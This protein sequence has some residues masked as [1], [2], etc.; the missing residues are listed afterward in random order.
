[1]TFDENGSTGSALAA[2]RRGYQAVPIRDG[3]K[4]PHVAGWVH[5]RWADED[6]ISKAFGQWAEEGAHGVGLLLGKPSGGLVDVDMDHPKAL[7]LRRFFL[8]PTSMQTGRAGRPQSHCWYRVEKGLPET[9]QYKMPDG[10][11]I[12]ELRSTGA[13]TV[14]PP[15]VHPTG[16]AYRWEGEPWG[17]DGPAKVDG[18]KLSW[19]VALTALGV[20]L[21][22]QWPAKGSRHEAYLAL[23]GGL[24][25]YGKDAVHPFWERNI[26]ILIEGL[27]DATH[28]RDGAD[29]RV[30]EV[31]PS[32]IK[33]LREGDRTYG[34]N[35]LGQM[36]G[37]DHAASA[38]RIA[39]E[40]ASLFGIGPGAVA[41]ST[42]ERW[43]FNRERDVEEVVEG[44]KEGTEQEKSWGWGRVDLE[45]YTSGRIVM[46][47][48]TLLRRTDGRG[49]FYPGRVNVLY[50][51][52][53]S[54]KSWIAM[55][56]GVQEIAD[57]GRL[58]FVDLEDTPEGTLERIRLLGVADDDLP[59]QF[60]YVNPE[61]PLAELQMGKYGPNVTEE[62]QANSKVFTAL[63]KGFD[64]SIIVLDGMTVLYGIHGLDTNDAS[65][66]EV[67]TGWLK[68]LARRGY[69]IILIDHTGKNGGKF[70]T[71][72][73]SGQKKAM[74]QG[75][76]YRV[77]VITRPVP[78][79]IGQVELA[80]AKDR[81]GKMKR[82]L[83][84]G[85]RQQAEPIAGI[86]TI[87]S[88]VDGITKVWIDPPDMTTVSAP[89]DDAAM[90]AAVDKVEK[91]SAADREKRR[92]QA[93]NDR[94]LDIVGEVAAESDESKARLP[95]IYEAFGD[96]LSQRTIR[97]RL[98][99]WVEKKALEVGG[100]TTDRW[101]RPI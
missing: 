36:I 47:E 2:F 101:Y 33:R 26:H 35:R 80:T 82:D 53:E 55:F 89:G 59:S 75:A 49:L 84:L 88:S 100:S 56:C 72:I 68:R 52:S 51:L 70:A 78:G 40:I 48:P 94:L 58:L 17:G 25:W 74:V 92:V 20:V 24:L 69:T 1:M 85:I 66:T 77:D 13:Q 67:I 71:P 54:A 12:I 42:T 10:T 11:M 45:P 44:A 38:Q 31:V 41:T 65:S 50:G 97:N 14:I 86:V 83:P 96:T 93:E 90:A 64:P 87:D 99:A 57:G 79:A 34:W 19:Q 29:T 60:A 5:Q 30:K 27:A 18:Q 7:T 23:A 39:K 63:L 98:A 6:Q 16:E 91:L 3:G 76:S 73:G 62:G 95:D 4:K 15:S 32:T 61:G 46:P 8:P 9:R 81:P 21:I 22:D 43:E 28:D 37:P